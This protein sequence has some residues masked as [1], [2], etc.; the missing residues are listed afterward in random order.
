[1]PTPSAAI[2]HVLAT[3][4]NALQRGD[5]MGAEI[6]LAPFFRG[7]MAANPDLLNIAGTLRMNQGRLEEA[8]GLFHQ[9]TKAAPREPI[10]AFNLGMTLSRLGKNEEAETALRAALTWIFTVR[11]SEL[12]HPRATA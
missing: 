1:M 9:A 6:A 3:A 11:R 8:A 7:Q 5:L 12:N 10:F 2:Q 4:T